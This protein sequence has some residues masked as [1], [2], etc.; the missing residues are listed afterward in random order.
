MKIINWVTILLFITIA[1][2]CS[3]KKKPADKGDTNKADDRPIDSPKKAIW[4]V[5]MD[6]LPK[7]QA[8]FMI[9]K[10]FGSNQNSGKC[11]TA[12]IFIP[13]PELERLRQFYITQE[14]AFSEPNLGLRFYF[15]QFPDEVTDP[16]LRNKNTL[17]IAPTQKSGSKYDDLG[18]CLFAV[19]AE[20]SCPENCRGAALLQKALT[21][22]ELQNYEN[23]GAAF[24]APVPTETTV[25]AGWGNTTFADAISII[26]NF[27]RNPDFG[28][29]CQTLAV[30]FENP[31]LKKSLLRL[32]K[33]ISINDKRIP[34]KASGVRIYFGTYPNSKQNTLLMMLTE[35]VTVN[36]N[37]SEIVVHQDILKGESKFIQSLSA[38]N[39]GSRYPP[40]RDANLINDLLN[41]IDEL[42]VEYRGCF[43]Q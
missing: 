12:S 20:V 19:G 21:P 41:A 13:K 32:A 16:A 37:G 1:D 2:S 28:G 24:T 42:P 22:T 27:S 10:F 33:L 11:K 38:L 9:Q 34:S 31:D 15:G 5:N 25:G 36:V 6:C 3:S 39:N 14:K 29:E 43:N 18:D 30:H 40:G 8:K 23:C 4:L 7:V 35:K 17:L 26:Q